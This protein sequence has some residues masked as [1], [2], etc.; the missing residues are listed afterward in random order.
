M[1]VL[2]LSIVFFGFSFFSGCG[3]FVYVDGPYHGRVFDAVTKQ[4]IEGAAV[5][6]VWWTESGLLVPHPIESVHDANEVVTDAQ[7]NFTIE[8]TTN[9]T[10]NPTFR[11]KTPQVTIFMP[12]YRVHRGAL[13]AEEELKL[14]P[15]R[16]LKTKEERLE[17]LTRISITY[18]VP[19]GTYPNLQKLVDI[20]RGNL[21]L[22]P[23][24]QRG[25]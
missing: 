19:R 25:R 4:P 18:K 20:E 10:L 5:V 24:Y 22:E 23:M 17:N 16:E 6:T 14:F 9:V 1:W 15:L 2:R 21:G 11:I 3:Q 12:G 13:L 7:G 8:G